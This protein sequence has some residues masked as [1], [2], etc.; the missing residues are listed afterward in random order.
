MKT[1]PNAADSAT[2]A[3]SPS[4]PDAHEC[5]SALVDGDQEAA[6]EACELW[7]NDAHA[8]R[9]WHS[10]H[11]IGDV[12]RSEDLAIRP[13]GDAA[14]LAKV[15]E[16]LAAEPIVVAPLRGRAVPGR[17]Q[18]WLLPA[19]AAA[20]VAVVAGVLVIA[21]VGSPGSSPGGAPVMATAPGASAQGLQ[22]VSVDRQGV[23]RDP[24][25]EELVRQHHASRGVLAVPVPG[26]L[27]PQSVSVDR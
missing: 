26:T 6:Q 1:V 12:M 11:L 13:Q 3:A 20:G 8:R 9:T 18:P 7:R 4:I 14:F 27:R 19:A 2:N 25:L 17:R 15:R 10:Y 5:L 24:R 23:L 16:R 21:R 22:T